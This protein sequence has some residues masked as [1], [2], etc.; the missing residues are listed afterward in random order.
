MKRL[1]F[2]M[3]LIGLLSSCS[4]DKKDIVANKW[5]YDTKQ[6]YDIST[7]YL[8][9]HPNK[10]LLLKSY[11]DVFLEK[12]RNVS[13]DFKKDGQLVWDDHGTIRKMKWYLADNDKTIITEADSTTIKY[14]ILELN[15]DKMVWDDNVINEDKKFKLSKPI[16]VPFSK[17]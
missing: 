17:K 2:L 9:E 1:G 15:K 13:F 11:N 12:Y 3:V 10:A 14:K 8:T 16:L 5:V 7:G 4:A 6:M